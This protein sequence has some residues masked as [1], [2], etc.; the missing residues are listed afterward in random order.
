MAYEAAI[1]R[2]DI[3]KLSQCIEDAHADQMPGCDIAEQIAIYD[4][5]VVLAE[6]QS[7]TATGFRMISGSSCP[8]RE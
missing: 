1:H 5:L 2:E 7:V 4:A 3:E 6:I 8:S